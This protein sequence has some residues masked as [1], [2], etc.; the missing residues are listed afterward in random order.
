MATIR[1]RKSADGKLR[2][3]VQVRLKGHPTQTATFDRKTD[4]RRWVQRTEADIREGRNLG[5]AESKRHTLGELIDRYVRDV[6]PSKKSWGEA[7]KQQLEW[8]KSQLG[9]YTLM[10]VTPSKIVE[11]RDSLKSGATHQGEKRSP[12]TV[13]RYLAALSHA[14]SIAVNEWGWLEN[15]P[16]SKVSRLTETRGR[17]RFLSDGE[18]EAL[19][20]ACLESDN[21]YLYP[22]VVLALSTGMRQGEILGL[23][24]EFV[25]FR[26]GRIT[27][28]ETKND[29]IRVVPLVA[30]ALEVLKEHSK[31]RRIDTPLLFPGK[32]NALKPMNIRASWK[33]ALK[34]ARIDDFRFHDL[35][36]TAA[37]Y[38]AMNGASLA[39]IAEVL[40]HKTLQ[41]VK[42]Y[43][44]LSEAHTAG[45]VERMNKKI[46]N[47][48]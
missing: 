17:V 40:G 13:N 46:F 16:I 2:Y 5:V 7:Q 3:Q 43:S 47:D 28:T 42:R 20:R 38:L 44:H 29:E 4:A 35:R 1:E 27:L 11:C 36:H 41:M 19:L 37:S 26:Q 6:L 48:A 9:A 23:T 14:F 15:N 10:H 8:W 45:V 12:A 22:V 31:V 30:K 25:D 21:R 34:V 18:R 32:T 39:E 33:V 24:W